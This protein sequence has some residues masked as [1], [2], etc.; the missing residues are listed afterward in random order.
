MFTGNNSPLACYNTI[1]R[2][3]RRRVRVQQTGEQATY[4][5]PNTDRWTKVFAPKS[6]S[7]TVDNDSKSVSRRTRSC[8]NRGRSWKIWRLRRRSEVQIW[9]ASSPSTRDNHSGRTDRRSGD[10]TTFN[11]RSGETEIRCDREKRQRSAKIRCNLDL[12]NRKHND[13]H[14][15]QIW[16]DPDSMDR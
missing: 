7:S 6:P 1:T 4:R 3:S 10:P 9:R 13:R 8:N 15:L 2:N 11:N 14:R 5:A 16:H 12:R